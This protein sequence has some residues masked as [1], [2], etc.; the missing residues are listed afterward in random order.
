MLTLQTT[1]KAK[2]NGTVTLTGLP[3]KEGEEAKLT[4]R[5]EK[6]PCQPMTARDLLQSGLVGI[7]KDRDDI[8]DSPE[9]ARRLREES[10]N[11]Q[12]S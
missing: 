2:K 10:Q 11:R 1:V 3:L 8:S 4:I 5:L 12:R 9:F 7:W 6:P